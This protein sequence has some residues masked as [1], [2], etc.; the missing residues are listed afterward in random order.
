MPNRLT[1]TPADA[2]PPLPG[3][4]RLLIPLADLFMIAMVS[5]PATGSLRSTWVTP[6]TRW[7]SVGAVVVAL[8]AVLTLHPVQAWLAALEVV[9]LAAVIAGSGAVALVAFFQDRALR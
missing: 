8:L 7:L 1:R 9:L 2:V 3:P 5:R 6:A 4:A